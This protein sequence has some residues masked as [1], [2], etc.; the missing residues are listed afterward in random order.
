MDQAVSSKQHIVNYV[1]CMEELETRE[2]TLR[3]AAE[4]LRAENSRKKQME[5]SLLKKS[6]SDLEISRYHLQQAEEYYFDSA[7]PPRFYGYNKEYDGEE[8]LR[9]HRQKKSNIGNFMSQYPENMRDSEQVKKVLSEHG[10]KFEK[11]P[12]APPIDP[13]PNKPKDYDNLKDIVTTYAYTSSVR[14]ILPSILYLMF[15]AIPVLVMHTAGWPISLFWVITAFAAPLISAPL[16]IKLHTEDKK[17][18]KEIN[19]IYE[20][21]LNIQRYEKGCWAYDHIYLP[22][23]YLNEALKHEIAQRE[24]SLALCEVSGPFLEAQAQTLLQQ[25]DIIASQKAKLYQLGIVPPDYRT[26]DCVIMLNSIFKNDLADTMRDAILLYDERVFRGEVL[27]GIQKIYDMLGK[28]ASSMRAIESHLMNV[29]QEVKDMTAEMRGIASELHEHKH[30]LEDM[31]K[32][33]RATR[34]AAESLQRSN[35]LLLMYEREKR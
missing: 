16:K 11:E 34:Y 21:K 20:H 13:S 6:R 30:S 5:Q 29:R 3:K 12:L 14:Y 28:L 9:E 27:K 33:S 32:E 22:M 10:W 4:E 25:A 31:V 35:E 17:H 19:K 7:N 2:F 23:F 1:Q 18:T 8:W 24:Q 15:V 26:L